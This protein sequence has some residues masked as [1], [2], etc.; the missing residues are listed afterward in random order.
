MKKFRNLIQLSDATKD[1]LMLLVLP[2]GL[3]AIGLVIFTGLHQDAA[4]EFPITVILGVVIFVA[5]LIVA[6][7]ILRQ[8]DISCSYEALGLPSGS[9]RSLIALSLIIIFVMLA[10]FLYSG[11]QPSVTQLPSNVT[12]IYSNGTITSTFNSTSVLTEP[13]EVQKNFSLQALTTISTLVVAIASFYFGSKAVDSARKAV[14]TKSSE[15]EI[16]EI[17]TNPSGPA[18]AAKGSPLFVTLE[19]LDKETDIDDL[20]AYGD[21]K[22]NFVKVKDNV[23]KYTPSSDAKDD[24]MLSFAATKDSTVKVTLT[25]KI[26]ETKKEPEKKPEA[27]KLKNGGAKPNES[28][29][30]A[31]EKKE[32]SKKEAGSLE[33]QVEKMNA[34][35]NKDELM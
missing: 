10:I 6:A 28:E 25:V 1:L 14:G 17:E 20:K 31:E 5:T 32:D 22:G 26:S 4:L 2:L 3:I 24:V 19:N 16:P 33:E 21:Q 15:T 29:K 8:L 18:Y 13:S 34:E 27:E 7:V 30:P 12:V 35:E 11:L 9:I 23:F